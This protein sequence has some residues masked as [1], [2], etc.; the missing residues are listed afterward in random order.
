[1]LYYNDYNTAFP[2]K[3]GTIVSLLKSL[4]AEGNIDGYGFQMHNNVNS[5]TIQQIREAV[6]TIGA[7]GLRLRVS[8][9]DI[10]VDDNSRESLEAQAESYA[11]V[12]KILIEHSPQIEAVQ[13]WG[14]KDD[15]S[16]R[17]EGYPL[18]FDDNTDP[19]PAFWAVC[20]PDSLSAP[21]EQSI[22]TPGEMAS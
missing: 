3:L 15:M 14:L 18:L 9:M 19:K 1:M 21:Q 13:V 20:D 12:M 22:L 16:W 10:T 5:P 11:A 7:L 8:E 17:K 6:D 4:I 2:E